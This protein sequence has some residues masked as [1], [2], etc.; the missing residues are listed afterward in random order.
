MYDVTKVKKS[1]KCE[2]KNKS[3][4][5]VLDSYNKT[6]FNL[7]PI[8]QSNNNNPAN[9]SY[10]FTDFFSDSLKSALVDF[11]DSDED[12]SENLTDVNMAKVDTLKEEDDDVKIIGVEYPP[13][14]QL[15]NQE[16]CEP[17]H[18]STSQT[19]ATP[20]PN[21]AA[22][23]EEYKGALKEFPSIFCEEI[24]EGVGSGDNYNN[25]NLLHNNL[26]FND[27]K[28]SSA[29][30]PFND[31]SSSTKNHFHTFKSVCNELQNQDLGKNKLQNNQENALVEIIK[32][33]AEV[34]DTLN[35]PIITHIFHTDDNFLIVVVS[36]KKANKNKG[37]KEVRSWILTY[38]INPHQSV[39]LSDKPLTLKPYKEVFTSVSL[40]PSQLMH[41]AIFNEDD[42]VR[43]EEL[44]LK[45]LMQQQDKLN[46]D[47]KNNEQESSKLNAQLE[48]MCQTT[49]GALMLLTSEGSV[50]L[51]SCRDYSVLACLNPPPD[52]AYTAATFC[53][54]IDKICL[55]TRNNDIK[56]FSLNPAL[57]S[58]SSSSVSLEGISAEDG[59]AKK[60]HHKKQQLEEL[61]ESF[62]TFFNFLLFY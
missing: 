17:Q 26:L 52:Q 28:K 61:S 27:D 48:R 62:Y 53:A 16:Y 19:I 55:T 36:S 54:G 5:S 58:S 40:L 44:L 8:N 39:V 24:F 18:L 15:H 50:L 20:F 11:L 21:N 23:Q 41:Q 30:E 10:E 4:S 38:L 32:L 51:A 47:N 3:M 14:V 9:D 31:N 35:Q 60:K 46:S 57:S 7:P 12:S 6:P 37:D 43:D 49:T 34:Q 13:I 22:V 2:I 56:Y 25:N 59:L 45:Q 29:S 42:D 33:P 1:T